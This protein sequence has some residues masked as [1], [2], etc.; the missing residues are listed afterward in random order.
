MESPPR[1]RLAGRTGWT[2]EGLDTDRSVFLPS[3]GTLHAVMLCVD[4]PDAAAAEAPQGRRAQ[5]AYFEWLVPGARRYA[6]DRVRVRGAAGP[7]A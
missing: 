2:D 4:F 6:G 5:Q 1:W 3:V 7:G